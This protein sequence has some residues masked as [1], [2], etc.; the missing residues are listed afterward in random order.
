MMKRTKW[1]TLLLVAAMAV[2]LGPPLA[3]A[4]TIDLAEWA[5]NIDGTVT[6]VLPPPAFPG[7]VNVAAFDQTTGLGTVTVTL[8]GFGAHYVGLFV[9]HEIDQTSN[10]FSNEFGSTSGAAPA[11]LSWEIDEPGWVFG[12]IF[13]N[14]T[15]SSLDNSNAVAAGSPDDVSMALA[16]GFILNAGDTAFVSFTASDTAPLSGF[17]LQQTDPDGASVYFRS[18]LD[19]HGGSSVPE[20]GILVMLGTGLVS[21]MGLAARSRGRRN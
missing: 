11:G 10:G 2:A 18:G 21:L 13:I 3:H 1:L 9:D 19:I 6:D 20:P 15:A 4:A 7:G 17:Y 16:Q 12:D 5:V 14:L 8:S